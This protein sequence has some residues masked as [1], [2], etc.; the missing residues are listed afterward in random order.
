MADWKKYCRNKECGKTICFGK[1]K[2]GCFEETKQTYTPDW[3]PKKFVV[4]VYA[5]DF[6][7]QDYIR[8]RDELVVAKNEAEA[9]RI[10]IKLKTG[11]L[12]PEEQRLVAVWSWEEY[13][14]LFPRRFFGTP[15]GMEEAEREEK[16][17][18]DQY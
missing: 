17:F 1:C 9:K 7:D 6:C 12:R 2:P 11:W 5:P 3:N 15:K 18:F 4:G 16:R 13:N 14:C 8:D 10:F